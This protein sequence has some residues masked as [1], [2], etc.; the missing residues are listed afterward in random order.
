MRSAALC[1]QHGAEE[2]AH[3]PHCSQHRLLIGQQKS[4]P[5]FSKILRAVF[6]RLVPFFFLRQ[7]FVSSISITDRSQPISAAQDR[8][9]PLLC[10]LDTSLIVLQSQA[11]HLAASSPTPPCLKWKC[12]FFLENNAFTSEMYVESASNWTDLDKLN[13]FPNHLIRQL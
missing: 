2:A 5:H 11:P 9:V 10:L 12:C 6:I 7:Q 1:H 3:Q 13:C 4:N 8:A